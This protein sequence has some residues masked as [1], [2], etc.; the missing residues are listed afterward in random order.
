M[1]LCVWPKD[2]VFLYT[3]WM[4]VS[5]SDKAIPSDD[6]LQYIGKGH[7]EQLSYTESHYKKKCGH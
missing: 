4:P 2:S 6:T 1:S 7:R 3:K 5:L